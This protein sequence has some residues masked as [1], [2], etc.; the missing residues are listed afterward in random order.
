[1][2]EDVCMNRKVKILLTDSNDETRCLLQSALERSGRFEVVASLGDG[3]QVVDM[4]RTWKPDLMVLDRPV[5]M[6]SVF[7]D[8]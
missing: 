4:V 5:W 1:M 8:G 7:F 2:R 6:D 3:T